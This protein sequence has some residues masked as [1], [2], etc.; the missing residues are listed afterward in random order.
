MKLAVLDQSPIA[1]GRSPQLALAQAAE[2]AGYDRYWVAEH[3]GSESFAGCAPEILIGHIAANTHRIRVGSGG[4]MLMHYSPLKVAEQFKVLQSLHPDR[5][6]LGIGRAPGGDGITSVALAYG[7]EVGPEYFPARLAD[8]L[9]FLG[10]APPFTESLA[11]VRPAPAVSPP[12]EPWM[13]GSSIDGGR[14]AAH[15]GLPF[16]FAHFIGADALEPACEVYRKEFKPSAWLQE[17]RVSVGVF[18]I[19]APD[20]SRAELLSRCRDVWRLKVERGVFEPFPSVEEAEAY[21]V[22][23]AQQQI[24]ESRRALQIAG[25]PD[26]VAQ[27]LSRLAGTVGADELAVVS[28]THAFEERVWSHVRIA[29]ALSRLSAS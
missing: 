15:F 18:A 22:S 26:Q 14:L 27:D 6:D 17:P 12:P 3:H 24:I 8:L 5:I 9:A 4:V 21:E 16:A 19:A 25:T 11:R 13:L 23:P 1:S 2:R 10:D 20:D 7:S 29:E 28:I